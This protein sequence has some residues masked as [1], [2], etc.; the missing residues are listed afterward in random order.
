MTITYNN[1]WGL[2]FTIDVRLQP[3]LR[4]MVKV[5][6][7]NQPVMACFNC[8][9]PYTYVE[10]VPPLDFNGTEE[11]IKN[12]LEIMYHDSNIFDFKEEEML[13]T[14]DALMLERFNEMGIDTLGHCFI[15]CKFAV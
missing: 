13:D 14:I 4:V 2:K 6:S 12:R 11:A 8:T 10:M 1:G 9:I 15:R 5:F 3:T 7:T